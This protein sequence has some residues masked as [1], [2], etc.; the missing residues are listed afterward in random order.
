MISTFDPAAAGI[1]V[2]VPFCA[3]IC[4]YCDFFRL[5]SEEVPL[6]YEELL[7]SEARLY[8]EE[9]PIEV[10]TVY[11]G[12]G[13]PSLLG[14]ARLSVLLQGLRR[15]F[16]FRQR[17][18]I[19]LEA[20]PETVTA[21]R[22]EG[23]REAGVNRLSIGVQSLDPGVLASLER[24]A[25]AAQA[26]EAVESAAAAGFERLSADLMSGVPGQDAGSLNRSLASLCGLPVDHLSIYSLDLHPKTRLWE[27]VVGGEKALPDDETSADMYLAVHSFLEAA[28]FEH[29]EV[30]NFARHGGRSLHNLRYWMGGDTIG[31]GPS[32]WTRF[33]KRLCGSPRNLELWKDSVVNGG[34]PHTSVE[35]LTPERLLEDRLIFGLRVSEGVPMEDVAIFLEADGR[36][37]E[38]VLAPLYEHGYAEEE[39]GRLKLTVLGFLSSNEILTYLLPDRWPQPLS[40]GA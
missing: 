18:E 14:P 23:W 35:P 5:K 4:G 13:T 15:I 34:A 21:R 33:R 8:A 40:P 1:Y 12:G 16:A 32:A 37:P 30:S 3:S 10:D 27:A 2:H 31:L 29:Y 6:G 7:L 24:R 25:S 22:L 26:R 28:G 36:R 38:A 39:D 19:T 17:M 9:R 11:F 20:N